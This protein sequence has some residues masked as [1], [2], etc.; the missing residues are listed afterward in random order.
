MTDQLAAAYGHLLTARLYLE[1]ELGDH[2]NSYALAD[3]YGMVV[4]ACSQLR[5]E[6]Q[7][8]LPE[9]PIM[10]EGGAAS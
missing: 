9:H 8:R 3:A 6:A 4:D 5:A 2:P 1:G 10:T 7:D